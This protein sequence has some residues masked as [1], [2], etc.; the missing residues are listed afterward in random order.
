MYTYAFWLEGRR[1][2]MEWNGTMGQGGGKGKKGRKRT[3]MTVKK[4]QAKKEE[5]EG[6]EGTFPRGIGRRRG[7]GRTERRRRVICQLRPLFSRQKDG[8]KGEIGLF[9]WGSS[10]PQLPLDFLLL[11]PRGGKRGKEW[12]RSKNHSTK[13]R[14]KAAK[15]PSP[16][17]S[18]LF[19][20]WGHLCTP[21][22]AFSECE[23]IDLFL[24]AAFG[25]GREERE[26]A[27]FLAVRRIEGG[28]GGGK[29]KRKI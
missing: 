2:L 26:R 8:G 16:L 7:E 18:P 22:F 5:E 28:R 23:T 13:I 3:L 14:A 24:V 12:R 9:Y 17:F 6:R 27:E 4:G 1:S 21:F 15:I 20:R 11:P 10:F 19:K 25:G 29:R